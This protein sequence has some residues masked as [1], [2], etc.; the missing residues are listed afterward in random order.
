MRAINLAMNRIVVQ[1]G[2]SHRFFEHGILIAAKTDNYIMVT[3]N[4]NAS[5]A[6]LRYVKKFFRTQED[7]N[8]IQKRIDNKQVLLCTVDEIEEYISLD[9]KR[10]KDNPWN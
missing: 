7:E 5:K 2:N 4:W 10:T 6:T 9:I 1:D 8:Q 3:H